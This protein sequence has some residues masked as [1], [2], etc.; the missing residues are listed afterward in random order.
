MPQTTLPDYHFLYFAPTLGAE[1]FFDASR[2]YWEAFQPTVLSDLNFLRFVPERASVAVTAVTRRDTVDEIGVAVAQV[3]PNA[4]YDAVVQD[5]FDAMKAALSERA[6]L[7]QPFG[8]P[9]APTLDPRINPT[10]G[11]LLIGSPAPT[12][13]PA[14]FVTQTPTPAPTQPVPTQDG[15]SAPAAPIEPTPGPILG[16]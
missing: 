15:A 11:G 5:M 7:N 8:V 9:L 14:G 13:A 1:W 4:Y 3:R 6:A 12:R 10:P 16:G 2:R